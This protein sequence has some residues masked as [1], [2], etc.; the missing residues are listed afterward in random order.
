M[1]EYRIDCH[2]CTNEA[3]NCNGDLYCLPAI[4]G[5]RTIYIED[6]HTGRRDDPD[7][8]CCDHYTTEPRQVVLYESEVQI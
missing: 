7:P 5:K 4:Q 8:I 2:K 3:I 6:G 1:T